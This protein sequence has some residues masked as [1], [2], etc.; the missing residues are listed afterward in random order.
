[1]NVPLV[2]DHVVAVAAH[3]IADS[4]RPPL[5]VIEGQIPNQGRA[6][7]AHP[8]VHAGSQGPHR[9]FQWHLLVGACGR[10]QVVVVGGDWLVS[11]GH[12]RCYSFCP[13]AEII[14][15]VKDVPFR[16]PFQIRVSL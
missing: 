16:R 9:R 11:A 8:A 12:G 5:W 13:D 14:C 3:H 7:D 6:H 2:V 10:E 4:Q 15:D 1:M